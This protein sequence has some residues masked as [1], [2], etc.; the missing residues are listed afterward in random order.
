MLYRDI[1]LN[2]SY[3]C[4]FYPLFIG[5]ETKK[6]MIWALRNYTIFQ[7]SLNKYLTLRDLRRNRVGTNEVEYDVKRTGRMLSDKA[8][9]TLKMKMMKAMVKDAYERYKRDRAENWRAWR[10]I[11]RGMPTECVEG[12]LDVWKRVAVDLK[13]ELSEKRKSKVEHLCTK[14]REVKKR[15]P[16]EYRNIRLWDECLKEEFECEPRIYGGLRDTMDDDQMNVLR[17]G[18]NCSVFRRIDVEKSKIDNEECLNKL[19]WNVIFDKIDRENG[20]GEVPIQRECSKKEFV[21]EDR[22]RVNVNNLRVTSL[23]YNYKV[24]MPDSI[25]EEEV[26]LHKYKREVE[27]VMRDSV[28]ESE[29]WNNL[30]DSESRGLQKL[31]KRVR[32]GEIVCYTTDKSG[33]WSVDSVENY[34]RACEEHLGVDKTVEITWEDHD[35]A[36][37]TMNAEGMALLRMLGLSESEGGDGRLWQV[38]KV[39]G[40]KVPP[41]YGMRKDHKKVEEGMEDVGPKVRPVCGARDCVTKRVSYI[42]SS[43]LAVLVNGESTHCW[44][45]DDMIDEI[46]RVNESGRIDEKCVMGSLDVDALYPSLDIEKCVS[47]IVDKLNESDLVFENV[48]WK[49]VGLYLRYHMNDEEIRMEGLRGMYREG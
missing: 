18:P 5:E 8:R 24:N 13:R 44:S 27:G 36:E 22:M 28:K 23:P 37:K 30:S 16:E 49:E 45:T 1:I 32:E 15:V 4:S 14:W 43:V 21:D 20:E 12:Y 38:L 19:R 40:V 33:R 42:L 47:V 17:R 9:M 39:E 11:R 34:K 26:R 7:K 48:D 35:R 29:K 41:F 3:I 10:E 25:G 31:K 6:R 2:L 46:K